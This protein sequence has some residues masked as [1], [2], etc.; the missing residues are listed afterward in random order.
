MTCCR[1]L[2]IRAIDRSLQKS[3]AVQKG[4]K[5]Q[6]Q[7]AQVLICSGGGC[8]SKWGS[9]L[10]PSTCEGYCNMHRD[11][12]EMV[13]GAKHCCPLS[14]ASGSQTCQRSQDAMWNPQPLKDAWQHSIFFR[15]SIFTH[16]RAQ[17]LLPQNCQINQGKQCGCISRTSF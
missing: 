6:R 10:L 1:L 5:Q 4:S 14:P 16:S 13:C 2:K 17:R 12:R 8:T 11:M 7:T 15:Y 3:L 9:V